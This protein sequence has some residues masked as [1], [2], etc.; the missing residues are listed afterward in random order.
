M[1]HCG[2]IKYGKLANLISDL[3]MDLE[4]DTDIEVCHYYDD[5]GTYQFT[6]C[7]N[8]IGILYIKELTRRPRNL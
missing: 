4:D 5:E 3:D 6:K 2:T 7:D 1:K 8:D